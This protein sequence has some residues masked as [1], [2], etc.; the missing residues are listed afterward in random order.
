MTP[1]RSLTQPD[2]VTQSLPAGQALRCQPEGGQALTS[3]PLAGPEVRAS[4][5]PRGPQAGNSK[6]QAP[7]VTLNLN[8]SHCHASHCGTHRLP[9]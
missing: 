5:T 7:T 3:G 1:S 8:L 2:S 4:V 9:A 6:P